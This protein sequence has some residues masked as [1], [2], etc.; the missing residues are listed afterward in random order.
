MSNSS[1][2]SCLANMLSE[3]PAVFVKLKNGISEDNQKLELLK[4]FVKESIKE[5]IS[6]C[7]DLINL[8]KKRVNDLFDVL[9]LI[10]ERVNSEASAVVNG[11]FILINI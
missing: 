6:G 10:K 7:Q 1:K 3:R 5:F 11:E 9:Q 8:I 4:K 2:P